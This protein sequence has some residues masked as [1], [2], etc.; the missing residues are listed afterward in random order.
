MVKRVFTTILGMA[1]ALF[2]V[3][4]V[5]F[6]RDARDRLVR[7]P[8]R[9]QVPVSASR[10]VSQVRPGRAPT[11]RNGSLHLDGLTVVEHAPN[12][13]VVGSL[14]QKDLGTQRALN[15]D[16]DLQEETSWACAKLR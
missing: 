13:T 4:A 7:D 2:A 5:S 9:R 1:A 8:E 11:R 10:D 15:G 14:S 12:A 16:L 6:A 3:D